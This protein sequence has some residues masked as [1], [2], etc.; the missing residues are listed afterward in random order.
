MSRRFLPT[1]LAFAKGLSWWRRVLRGFQYIILTE[2][3][4]NAQQSTAIFKVPGLLRS[5]WILLVRPCQQTRYLFRKRLRQVRHIHNGSQESEKRRITIRNQ[6]ERILGKNR[7]TILYCDAAAAF[8][9]RT[10]TPSPNTDVTR[11]AHTTH[12][13]TLRH[14]FGNY[15]L[16]GNYATT[17]HGYYLCG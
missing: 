13:Q 7:N 14:Q 3:G 8:L 6:R 5:D 12:K 9:T 4:H 15:F 16:F 10:H 11:G 2:G 17:Y 1:S